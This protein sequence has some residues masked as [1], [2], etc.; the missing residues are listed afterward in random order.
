M[1]TLPLP[2]SLQPSPVSQHRQVS[3]AP[4]T[5]SLTPSVPC[6]S[7]QLLAPFNDENW[8]NSRMQNGA[9]VES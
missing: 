5:A 6:L 7:S 9:Q 2:H 4:Q 1:P 8:P 3:S